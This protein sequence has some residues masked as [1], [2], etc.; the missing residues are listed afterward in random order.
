MCMDSDLSPEYY[1]DESPE[2]AIKETKAVIAHIDSIDPEHKLITPILTPRFAPS[3]SSKL[4][5]DLGDLA[6]KTQLPIQ[7]HISEN[8][9]EIDLVRSLFPNH[10]SYAEVYSAYN[11]LTPKTV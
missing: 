6:S 1:R 8:T 7:T 10:T 4:L 5:S 3:C 2:F 11:L 9:S